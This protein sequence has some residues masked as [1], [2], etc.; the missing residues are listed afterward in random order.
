MSRQKELIE[1]R[2]L[3]DS[4]AKPHRPISTRSE[5]LLHAASDQHDDRKHV[6]DVPKGMNTSTISPAMTSA[7]AGLLKKRDGSSSVPE[8]LRRLA[9]ELSENSAASCLLSQRG[10]F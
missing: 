4:A 10:P 5:R 7:T 9:S 2:S 6:K 8:T 3:R 1:P